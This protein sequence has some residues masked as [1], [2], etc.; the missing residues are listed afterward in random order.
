[1]YADA[2]PDTVLVAPGPDVTRQTPTLPAARAYPS[3]HAPLLV[4]YHDV[5]NIRP[6]ELIIQVNDGT[7]R[8]SED[9]VHPFFLQ[10]L[11]NDLCACEFNGYHLL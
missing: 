3:A 4:A 2:I 5:T 11:Y 10:C 7:S 9:G 1:M 6:H 8:I